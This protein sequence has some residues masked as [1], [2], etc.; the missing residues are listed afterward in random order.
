VIEELAVYQD[1]LEA[2]QVEPFITAL[3]DIGDLLPDSPP[4]GFQIPIQWR[5]GF[6]VQHSLEKLDKVESRA[7]TLAL[8]IQ[9][10]S[11][12]SMATEVADILTVESDDETK[13]P[14]LSRAQATEV[15]TAGLHKIENAAAAG[16]LAQSPKLAR[17]LHS[18]RRWGGAE[19][20]IRYTKNISSSAEGTLTLLK[21]LELRSF[22]QQIG[23]YAGTERYYFQ[24]NDIEPLISMDMLDE[25]VKAIPE[26]T[27]DEQ[28]RRLVRNFRRAIERRNTGRPDSGPFVFD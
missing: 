26:E 17:L 25:S 16:T 9:N 4:E 18:W 21:S 14:F 22:F 5:V 6:L 12:L 28:G 20:A 1:Q 24:R 7:E 11:G 13:T 8:A 10:T 2:Q 27:L 15:R 19:D 3:F 23:D